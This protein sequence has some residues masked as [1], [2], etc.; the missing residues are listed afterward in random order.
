M[1][2]PEILLADE[3]TGNLDSRTGEQVLGHLFGLVRD[4]NRTLVVVTHNEDVAA[5]CDRSLQLVDGALG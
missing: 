4:E 3:P 1:N 2:E 5:H